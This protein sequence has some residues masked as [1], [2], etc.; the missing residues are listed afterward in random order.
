MS[1]L[2][3]VWARNIGQVDD[4]GAAPHR[5]GRRVPPLPSMDLLGAIRIRHLGD[6]AAVRVADNA[7]RL[8]ITVQGR[9]AMD[10]REWP[11]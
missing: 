9:S 7:K 2:A 3:P 8:S 10:V 4:F 6:V 5:T 11:T 1:T